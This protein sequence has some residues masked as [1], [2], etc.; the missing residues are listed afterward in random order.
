MI[1]H[2]DPFVLPFIVGF[3]FLLTALA[4]LYSRWFIQLEA[5]SHPKILSAFFSLKTLNAIK[6]VFLEC[7]IHR[8]I[9]KINPMLGYMHMSL[10]FGWF[11]LILF[12]KLETFIYTGRFAN[13]IYY[14]IFF[15][16]FELNPHQSALL[17]FFNISMDLLL[18]FVLSGV[19]LAIIKRFKS[20]VTGLK[21]TTKHTAGDR[22]ALSTLWLIFPLRLLSESLTAAFSGNG[23]IITQPLGDFLGS[24]L[25]AQQLAYISWWGYSVCLG[26]FMA[27]LPFS[28]YMHIPTEI[29]LIFLRN[30]G[31]FTNKKYSGV[32][33]FELHAC[34]RCGICI[35][36]CP[37]NNESGRRTTQM[38]YFLRDLREKKLKHSI[39]ENCMMCGRCEQV[40]PVAIPLTTQRQ[41]QR[42]KSMQKPF[43]DFSYLERISYNANEPKTEVL[44]FAGCMSHLTPGIRQ[45][46]IK[47]LEASGIK[48]SFLDEKG[49]VCCGRPLKLSGKTEEAQILSEKNRTLIMASGAHTLVTSCPICYKSFKEDYHLNIKILHHTEFIDQLL[50]KKQIAIQRSDEKIAYHDPCELGR[51]SAIY[52]QPRQI[53][54]RVGQLVKHPDERENARCC[55]GS[56]ANLSVTTSERNEIQQSVSSY[57]SSQPCD[58]I[59]TACPMCKKSI[60][61]FAEKPVKDIAELV[62]SGLDESFMNEKAIK[63]QKYNEL[64]FE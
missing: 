17:N 21:Q 4:V 5:G 8:K 50:V 40:C 45:S 62:A 12:G 42:D 15:R 56:L 34:S 1:R 19:C 24:F 13:A 49:P 47:I 11:L 59:A 58:I 48:Y 55:G 33:N 23:S 27:A 7:L 39:T 36:V 20:R 2:F 54:R 18:L 57:L 3:T 6:E 31:I 35:D 43:S 32:S 25:P 53:I 29:F 44:Y 41:I 61:R 28:R 10:A 26:G 63:N 22:W 14:P 60:G 9:F 46:M 64:I 51:G 38:V 16:F 52:N 30:W 37:V